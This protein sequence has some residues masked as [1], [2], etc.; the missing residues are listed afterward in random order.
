[1]ASLLWQIWVAGNDVIWNAAHH[2]STS[3]GMT[4]LD[5]WQQWQEVHKHAPHPVV[6]HVTA[7]F[8]LDLFYYLFMCVVCVIM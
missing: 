2:T 3:I 1:V 8:S 4:A 6:Q 7:Q 5:A